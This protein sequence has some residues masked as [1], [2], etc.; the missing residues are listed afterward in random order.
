MTRNN[1][2]GHQNRRF[3][4]ALLDLDGTLYRGDNPISGADR[5][6]ARLRARG[7]QPVFFTNNATSTPE[8]V[9]SRLR[10]FHVDCEPV[11][12]CT[13]AQGAAHFIRA[14]HGQVATGV[15]GEHGLLQALVDEGL[16]PQYADPAAADMNLLLKECQVAVLGLDRY[17]TYHSLAIFARLVDTLGEFVLTNGDVR[18]P[19]AD[20]FNPGNGALGHLVE[21]ATGVQPLVIGKPNPEFVRYALGRF[22]CPPDEALIVGDNLLTDIA[23]GNQACVYS[24]QV[25]SGVQARDND[26]AMGGFRPQADEQ[27]DSIDNLF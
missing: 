26:T 11:E 12:V 17:C 20:G 18:L 5:F 1:G 4:V 15:V 16:K 19:V 9:C 24:V 27:V 7:I 23:A 2:A 8:Q 10:Q 6:V 13:S 25:Q 14:R 3:R 21:T 22:N